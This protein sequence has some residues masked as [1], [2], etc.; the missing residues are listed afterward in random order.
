MIMGAEMKAGIV[1]SA[2]KNKRRG[3]PSAEASRRMMKNLLNAAHEE[4]ARKGYRATTMAEIAER[5]GLTKRTLYQWHGDKAGLF[6]A[7]VE[8]GAERFPT[9]NLDS[10]A[11]PR[12]ALR[13]YGLKLMKEIGDENAYGIGLLFMRERDEFPEI[14]PTIQRTHDKYVVQPLAA[15]L[16]HHGLEEP[17]SIARTELFIAMVAMPAHN[18]LLLGRPPISQ[19][20]AEAH[21]DLAI[22]Y[23]LK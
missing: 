19:K 4:F 5:A 3:R 9:I 23:F 6:L 11:A 17:D 2:D 10:S 20:D 22:N 21:V 1:A 7:C 12:D 15:Y 8:A 13:E 18:R 16:R 14:T